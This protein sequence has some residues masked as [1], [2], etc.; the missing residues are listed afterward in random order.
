MSAESANPEAVGPAGL[1]AGSRLRVNTPLVAS[2]IIDGE[3]VL[4]HFETGCYYSAGR[5]GAEV[6]RLLEA[7]LD[8]GQIV[9]DLADR[10]AAPGDVREDVFDFVGRLVEE[11]LV[12]DA[13]PRDAGTPAVAPADS[14]P[15][16]EEAP[17]LEKYTDLEDL[18]L[19]DP[20]HDADEAGWPVAKPGPEA[21]EG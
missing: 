20:I 16:L 1:S 5:G 15:V 10:Y 18:L 17:G 8:L 4:I 13:P 11:G 19:L 14:R 12:A 3:A 21:P 6:L 2:Q 9:E 7:G